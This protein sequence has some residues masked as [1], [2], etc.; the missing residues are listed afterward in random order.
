MQFV[1]IAGSA[2]LIL[3][4]L[5]NNCASSQKLFLVNGLHS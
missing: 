3:L 2:S 1:G 4:L 5:R